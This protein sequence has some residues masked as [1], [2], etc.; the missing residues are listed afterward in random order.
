GLDSAPAIDAG[1]ARGHHQQVGGADALADLQSRFELAHRP[2]PIEAP[3][4]RQLELDAVQAP[5]LAWANGPPGRLE[6]VTC[7][8]QAFR[9]DLDAVETCASSD[10]DMGGSR[11][12]HDRRAVEVDA[13]VR[14]IHRALL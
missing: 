9:A 14:V 8:Q 12:G 11:C 5:D 10:L 7:V 6:L 13:L 2:A 1:L 3:I 4:G